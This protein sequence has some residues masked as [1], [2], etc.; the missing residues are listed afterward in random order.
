MK[1]ILERQDASLALCTA[2][3]SSKPCQLDRAF[4]R[5][6]PA[7]S[8]KDPLKSGPCRELS[9]QRALVQVMKQ[10]REVHG[11]RGFATND[12]A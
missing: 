1:G 11:A 9:R 3:M 10:I 6:C 8:E 2:L 4:N 5:F 12:A 7:I